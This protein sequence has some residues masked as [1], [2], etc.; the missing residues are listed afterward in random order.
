MNLFDILG[1][2]MVGPSSSHTA[3][4][5]RIGFVGYRPLGETP[6]KER[7]ELHG[8]FASTGKGHGTAKALVAG[9][10]GMRPDDIR[11]P[12]SFE[13]AQERGMEFE[14]T[15]VYLK[16]VH[17]NS[18]R[19]TLTGK[20]GKVCTMIASSLGGGRIKVCSLEGIEVSFSGEYPT[21]I[22]NNEDKPGCVTRVTSL[23]SER[24]IN[25]ATMQPYRDTRGGEAVMVI[26]CDQGVPE[27]FLLELEFMVDST[28]VT[29]LHMEVA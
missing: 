29:Y 23:L 21:L 6:V 10:L 24:R 3:G 27:P 15:S 11:I 4:A 19:L 28:N 5:A 26:D 9:L 20:S 7:I 25:I 22:V 13:I 8:S 16:D 18:V 14:I 17:P 2:I 1:P 12:K